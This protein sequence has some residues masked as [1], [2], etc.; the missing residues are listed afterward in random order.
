[1]GLQR[2]RRLCGT[3]AELTNFIFRF[4]ALN[5]SPETMSVSLDVAHAG[6]ELFENRLNRVKT[7]P[8]RPPSFLTPATLQT[9][10]HSPTLY[11]LPLSQPQPDCTISQSRIYR[12]DP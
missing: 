4:L 5:V 8:Q 12:K 11:S 9:R 2:G 3:T 10:S 7:P 6:P 1:M